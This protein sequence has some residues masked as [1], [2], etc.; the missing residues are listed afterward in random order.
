MGKGMTNM[1]G[2]SSISWTFAFIIL[3]ICSL[4]IFHIVFILW[5]QRNQI[6]QLLEEHSR[7]VHSLPMSLGMIS[8]VTICTTVGALMN[9][10]ISASYIVGLIIG[11]LVSVII[12]FPFKDNIAIIDGVVSGAM[13]GQMGVMLAF[14]VPEAGLYT[15]IVLLTILFT[16]TWA[17]MR[18]SI[19]NFFSKTSSKQLENHP[20][21][22]EFS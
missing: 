18:R 10:Y 12:S 6:H 20:Q 13:G 17:I 16:V 5:R 1:M 19:Y 11:I 14:M 3:I 7:L 4:L 8:A 21:K 2:S 15:V 22:T 9:A